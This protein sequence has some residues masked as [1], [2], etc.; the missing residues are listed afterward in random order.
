MNIIIVNFISLLLISYIGHSF[1]KYKFNN[2]YKNFFIF[3]CF[4]LLISII[5]FNGASPTKAIFILC[6]NIIYVFLIFKGE[7]INK[8][9]VVIPFYTIQLLSEILVGFLLKYVFNINITSNPNSKEYYLALF[10]ST[11]I[12]SLFSF[13]YIKLSKYIRINSLPKY[14][15]LIFILPITT[16]L[17]LVGFDDYFELL[18][19]NPNL[20]FFIILLILSNFIVIIIFFL[21]VNNTNIKKE[22]E[23]M[24]Y[25][26]S[27]M[28]MKYNLLSQ[29]YTNNF[30]LLHDLLHRCN[31]INIHLDN[32]DMDSV[33]REIHI[34]SDVVFKQFNMIY[35]N[36]IVVNYIINNHLN[37][38]IENKINFK[39]VM[40]CNDFE[41]IS[42][43]EQ[44]E[45]F[46]Y[47]IDLGIKTCIEVDTEK[48]III[49]KSMKKHSY[50]I[51]QFIY[52]NAS[53]NID[54]IKKKLDTILIHN[55]INYSIKY[56]NNNTSIL[57][58]IKN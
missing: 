8:L 4:F 56:K 31:E 43:E 34:L 37:I 54:T 33:N 9:L 39:S 16:I 55:L 48:R 11:T 49:L 47:L 51:I 45:I 36:S 18:E 41:N 7:K 19:T 25:K 57:L 26:E 40:L 30:N 20:L 29:H 46:N 24:Q 23:I 6:I 13:I 1:L 5:N 28:N 3:F 52:P 2:L 21:S 50:T 38:I 17:F 53:R 14:T 32:K 12:L 58:Y 42:F 22:L 27:S 10:L 15:W 35:S 44:F